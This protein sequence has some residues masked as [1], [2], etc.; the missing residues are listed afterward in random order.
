MIRL[1]HLFKSYGNVAAVNDLCLDVPS[2]ELFCFLGP[3]GAGKT[4]SIKMMT[5]LVRP[6]RGRITL[7]GVDALRNPV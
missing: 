6:D 2:G 1:E 5:G 7:A 3:N 4:T